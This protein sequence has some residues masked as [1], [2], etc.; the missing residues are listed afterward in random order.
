M[1]LRA[2]VE[3][4]TMRG[5]CQLA[6]DLFWATCLCCCF[7][8]NY[9]F[10]RSSS[11]RKCR[12]KGYLIITAVSH[13]FI[14]LTIFRSL[15]T[16]MMLDFNYSF[17]HSFILYLY[18]FCTLDIY[19][20]LSTLIKQKRAVQHFRYSIEL[21]N[22]KSTFLDKLIYK[23]LS[24]SLYFFITEIIGPYYTDLLYSIL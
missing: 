12:K 21:F 13:L 5:H 14:F 9:S 6:A 17:I 20:I 19:Q 10:F 22:Q 4:L 18:M 7:W 15:Y 8:I 1:T 3:R 16:L 23:T 11:D 2:V 24:L